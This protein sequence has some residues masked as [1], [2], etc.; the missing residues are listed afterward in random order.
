MPKVQSL[1]DVTKGMPHTSA[2]FSNS[3]GEPKPNG[4][5]ITWPMQ[6]G[7]SSTDTI[8]CC[9]PNGPLAAQECYIARLFKPYVREATYDYDK[10]RTTE[11][12]LN[13]KANNKKINNKINRVMR[14]L[15]VAYVD[16][17]GLMFATN[18][19]K[20]SGWFSNYQGK[21]GL[22]LNPW[23]I[24]QTSMPKLVRLV[25]KEVIHRALFRNLLQ[26]SDKTV[27]NFTLD[28]LAMRVVATNP[29]D[30]LDKITVRLA[31]NL[32]NPSLYKQWPFLCLTDPSLTA[33]QVK[34]HM[35]PEVAAIWCDLY[36]TDNKGF[37][38]S[39]REIKPSALYF[40]IKN[41]MPETGKDAV[42]SKDFNYPWNITADSIVGDNTFNDTSVS[43][44]FD[45]KNSALNQAVQQ[46]SKPR[47]FRNNRNYN[48]S[49][50]QFWKEE[51]HKK[52]DF[53]DDNLKALSRRIKTQRLIE[54]IE[55]KIAEIIGRES[56]RIQP[57]PE[58]LSDEGSMMLALG[59]SDPDTFPFYWNSEESTSNKRKKVSAF[60]DLSPSMREFYP[61][62]VKITESIEELCGLS[63]HVQDEDNPGETVRG[64][65]TFAG[66]VKTL[67]EEE[68]M[69]MKEGVFQPG[70]STRFDSV[71][72]EICD[73]V[74]AE[75]ID[76]IL[77][78]T[79][80]EG[81]IQ[82][83]EKIKQFNESGK[84]AFKIYMATQYS[85]GPSLD[86]V[87][88]DFDK[89]NGDSFTLKLPPG[90]NY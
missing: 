39:L 58:Q 5:F 52:K 80:G 73:K 61:Y 76:I 89:L 74:D 41:V 28:V 10:I 25:K 18:D 6:G 16:R 62:M 84:Q 24:L 63:M 79:D 1:W 23:V 33:A 81:G 21:E 44:E 3:K 12:D 27:L 35:P 38:P 14:K 7:K 83:E 43:N 45:K 54:D 53:V 85:K 42:A 19:V 22:A 90:K 71:L 9:V 72:D 37:L 34:K 46:D 11:V 67:Y 64:A 82:D 66:H 49:V 20:I 86:H 51:V 55:G 78:F 32:F 8:K 17:A 31:E 69:K 36:E 70:A 65:Y 50:T 75:N 59:I 30:K 4:S 29:Y 57:Y 2:W 47:R 13:D 26:L 15:G 77:I 40:R 48:N 60:F 68:L 56:S 87:V 88:S